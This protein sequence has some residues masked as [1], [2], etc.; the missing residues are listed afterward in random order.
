MEKEIVVLDADEKQCKKLCELLEER[1]YQA[2]PMHSLLDLESY[3]QGGAC[4][5]V[6]LDIDTLSVDNRMIR[7]LTITYP[8]VYFLC[9]SEERFHPELKEAIGSHFYACLNKPVDPDELL[10]LLRGI[11]EDNSGPTD[12]P[13][14]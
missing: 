10:Y 9:L 8:G 6:I 7:E 2:I 11:Y 5:A 1:H 3:I 4:L 13:E 12:L 14:V